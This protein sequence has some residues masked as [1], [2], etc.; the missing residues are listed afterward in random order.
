[1]PFIRTFHKGKERRG[2]S[3]LKRPF[4][5]PP[6]LVSASAAVWLYVH[7][8]LCLCVTFHRSV[9]RSCRFLLVPILVF[10]LTLLTPVCLGRSLPTSQSLSAPVQ[11]LAS[12]CVN[13]FARF[14]RRVCVCICTCSSVCSALRIC[15][16]YFGKLIVPTF[17]VLLSMRYP[18]RMTNGRSGRELLELGGK[19][20]DS[21]VLSHHIKIACATKEKRKDANRKYKTKRYFLC[22]L[23]PQ[24]LL[25]CFSP[26]FICFSPP[27]SF[28]HPLFFHSISSCSTFL[29]LYTLFSFFLLYFSFL[30][31]LFLTRFSFLH[32]FSLENTFISFSVYLFSLWG[33]CC[34]SFFLPFLLAPLSEFLI[35]LYS[36]YSLCL[37]FCF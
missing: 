31:F 28:S 32:I 12:E 19:P 10:R 11:L 37:F 21:D 15:E 18:T 29:F 3:E 34:F 17:L 9:S 30:L 24:S 33:S 1:M 23:R 26:S 8:F 22:I 14:C 20:G 2:R 16:F 5:L 7:L 36:S 27:P 6:C 4:L 25:L 35:L 13:V